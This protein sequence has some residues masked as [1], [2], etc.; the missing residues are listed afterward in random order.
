[1][2]IEHRNGKKYLYLSHVAT[3]SLTTILQKSTE[4]GLIVP[5]DFL[6]YRGNSLL[7]LLFNFKTV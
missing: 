1:M 6:T 5:N 4:V 2:V 3:I 7:M